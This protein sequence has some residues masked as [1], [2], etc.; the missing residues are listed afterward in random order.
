MFIDVIFGYIWNWT[1]CKLGF[2]KWDAYA[3]FY[4]LKPHPQAKCKRCGKGY[5]G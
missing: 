2:H 3:G 1:S 5:N 4:E